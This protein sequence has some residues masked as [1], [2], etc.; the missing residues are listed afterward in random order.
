MVETTSSPRPSPPAPKAFGVRE[1]RERISQTRSEA[2]SQKNGVKKMGNK[3]F[4]FLTP[5]PTCV[6]GGLKPSGGFCQKRLAFRKM[7]FASA[8]QGLG[9]SAGKSRTGSTGRTISYFCSSNLRTSWIP[10]SLLTAQKSIA[11]VELRKSIASRLMR[12]QEP[13]SLK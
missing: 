9:R 7:P 4:I 2:L 6:G 8:V 1:E 5:C 11:A 12:V 13:T 3:S 10:E